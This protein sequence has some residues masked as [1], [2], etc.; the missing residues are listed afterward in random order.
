MLDRDRDGSGPEVMA[1]AIRELPFQSQ[2]SGKAPPGFMDGLDKI[3]EL[4]QFPDEGARQHMNQPANSA[5]Q[6]AV[7]LKGWPRL[8]ETFIAQ[9]L[10]ALEARGL[11]FDV[12]SMRHPT[13]T[14]RH[15][16]HDAAQG[17]GP[18]PARI[19]L[20]GAVARPERVG[21]FR[22]PARLRRSAEAMAET[23]DARPDA[24]P[25]SPVRTGRRACA[26]GFARPE[27]RLCAFPAHAVVGRALCKHDAR[28]GL[29]LFGARQGH[30]A[31][32]RLGKAGQA[33]ARGVRRHLHGAGRRASA[34]PVERP[35]QARPR[36]SRP[37]PLA[38]PDAAAATPC[39][40]RLGR[41]GHDR[42]GRPPGREEGLRP[43]ARSLRR[44]AACSSTGASSTSVA[45]TSR[46]S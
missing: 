20:P 13:D 24:Q 45:A 32:A 6:L 39:P 3:I 15:A 27:V 23:P 17:K 12:W 5:G 1:R 21:P 37:R 16:L 22:S 25:G 19:S 35:F 28:S 34:R 18:L 26:R 29:G 2:P 43:S 31:V 38:L 36:L 8:S 14:K 11:R 40:R 41:T 10:V 33:G 30:M 42:F 4:A 9:E 46:R 7:V 44:A